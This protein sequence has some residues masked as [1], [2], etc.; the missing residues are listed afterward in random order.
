MKETDFKVGNLITI[1]EEPSYWASYLCSNSPI[2]GKKLKYP[3]T[4]EIQGIKYDS[5]YYAMKAGDYGWDLSC[6]VK[7]KK[8]IKISQKDIEPL[9]IN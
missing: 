7:E 5:D 4:I 2:E 8:I 1:K 3:I 9:F 6:L